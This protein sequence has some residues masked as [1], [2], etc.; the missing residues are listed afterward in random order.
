MKKTFPP[1][2]ILLYIFLSSKLIVAYDLN[3]TGHIN[4]N[5][6]IKDSGDEPGLGT[7]L[8]I[9]LST[10]IFS[11][12]LIETKTGFFYGFKKDLLGIKTQT[13]VI[14]F[15]LTGKFLLSDLSLS[16]QSS[17]YFDLETGLSIIMTN[18]HDIDVFEGKQTKEYGLTSGLGF[19]YL[20]NQFDINNWIY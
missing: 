17:F 6:P 20:K 4:I 13:N 5:V 2:F 15:L 19:G 7:G 10:P 8:L 3:L 16:K 9:G 14:P 18:L 11:R 12:L 1:L